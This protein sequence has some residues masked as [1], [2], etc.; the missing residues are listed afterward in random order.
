[1]NTMAKQ[2]ED[3]G[4]T[5]I[6]DLKSLEEQGWQWLAQK[7]HDQA[8]EVW[9]EIFKKDPN[10]KAA[11]QGK[12]AALREKHEFAAA[13]ELLVKAAQAHPTDPGILSER[14]WLC[15]KQKKYD[16]AIKAFDEVL[17]VRKSDEGIFLWKISL[18]RSQRRFEEARKVI[19]EAGQLFGGSPRIANERGWLHF[20][21][22]QYDEAIETFEAILTGDP[23]NESALQGQIASLRTKGHYEEATQLANKSLLHLPGSSGIYSER[24]WIS[25]EQSRYEDAEADF[26][27]VLSLLSDDP[28][29]HINLAWC[30][31]RQ[32][33]DSDLAEATKRCREALRLD[34]NLAEAFGCLGNIAFKRGRIRE[35]EANFLRSIQLDPKRGH[36]ADLGAL[37]IQM[38]RYEEA[39]ERLEK[40][41]KNNPDDAYAHIEMGEVYLHTDRIK[42][43]IREFRI[44]AVIDPNNAD[45]RK[46]LAIALMENNRLIE[47]EKVLRDGIRRLDESKRWE[48]H[49]T[50]CRLLTRLG[51]EAGDLQF[52]EEALKEVSAAIRLKPEHPA[53]YFHGGIVRFKLEDYRKALQNFR[54]SLKEDEHYLEAELN[55]RRVKSLI[56]REKARSRA[57]RFASGFLAIIFLTQL[58]GL[59]VLRYRTNTITDTMLTIM[60]PILLGLMVVAV[61]LPSLSKLKMTGLEAELSEPAPKDSLMS[62]PKGEIGFTSDSPKSL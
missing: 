33:S 20:Y 28:S 14:A 31:V 8:I 30:L 15:L 13:G 57:G 24:G 25:F 41:V 39:K 11:F 32:A 3:A 19:D 45:S 5:V 17:K 56:G 37:Y 49:L 4:A 48:L 59:W 60:V 35:A 2:E 7:R 21:Q 62:G 54:R 40:A 52:Y 38:G 58:A 43:A 6:S 22:M 53:P 18:L 46:A 47:A 50:L 10:N 29:V 16:A 51:D 26:R 42:E 12:I 1:M 23:H 44:A 61:L 55:A 34:P 27:K 9:D 36:F